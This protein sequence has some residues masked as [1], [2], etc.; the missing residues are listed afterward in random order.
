MY[1]PDVLNHRAGF[2][3][4]KCGRSPRHDG[5]IPYHRGYLHGTINRLWYASPD[6]EQRAFLGRVE[7]SVTEHATANPAR[8]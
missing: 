8:G 5:G 1:G 3:D 6:Y 2:E 7:R 4:G